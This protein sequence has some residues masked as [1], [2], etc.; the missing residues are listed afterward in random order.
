VSFAIVLFGLCFLLQIPYT[1][2]SSRGS[3]SRTWNHGKYG[4]ILTMITKAILMIA[5]ICIKMTIFA[6][7]FFVKLAKYNGY[8]DAP[9]VILGWT[10]IRDIANMFF[11]VVLL[12][13]AFG[14]I[15]GLEQ[16]EWKK[17]MVNFI[18]AA[19]FINFSN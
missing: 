11:V 8:V 18:L 6:L 1:Q 19:I 12:V 15:L 3:A 10:M 13:I 4:Y 9:I 14:T 17:T 7:E 5:Q 16:Y 2:K